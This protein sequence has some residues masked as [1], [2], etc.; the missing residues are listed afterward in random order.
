MLCAIATI[1]GIVKI[2]NKLTNAVTE[3]ASAVSLS[4]LAANITVLFAV[5]ADAESEQATRS[6]PEKPKSFN[7]RIVKTGMAISLRKVQMNT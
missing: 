6:A 5:G 4:N 1:T 7:E 3:D 2:E